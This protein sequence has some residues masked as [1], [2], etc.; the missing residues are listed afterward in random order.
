MKGTI[1]HYRRGVATQTD[2]QFIVEVE[3]V[4][5]RSKA[6][7]LMGKKAV[8]KSSSGKQIPGKVVHTHGDNGSIRIRFAR[9]LPG[10]AIGSK[11]EI[12]D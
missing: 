7:K 4:D 8:W 1:I 10:Q 2:N 6:A 5:S 11:L 3:G 12:A 9:G